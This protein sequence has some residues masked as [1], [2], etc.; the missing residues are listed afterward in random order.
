MGVVRAGTTIARGAAVASL[1]LALVSGCTAL[2][3]PP[4][5]SAP[6]RW[7]YVEQ[8]DAALRRRDYD[9]AIAAYGSALELAER[10]RRASEESGYHPS[11]AAEAL[12]LNKLADAYAGRRNFPEA[13]SYRQRA[14]EIR[15]REN[16]PKS[17]YVADLLNDLGYDYRRYGQYA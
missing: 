5:G 14:L 9:G 13:A 1:G 10:Y 6:R 7:E 2:L 11:R 16:G 17:L 12:I 8:G 3:M 15:E 4:D